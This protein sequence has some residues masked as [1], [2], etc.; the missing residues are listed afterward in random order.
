MKTTVLSVL[1]LLVSTTAVFAQLNMVDVKELGFRQNNDGWYID[2]GPDQALMTFGNL[3]KQREGLAKAWLRFAFGNEAGMEQRLFW[4][5]A[6]NPGPKVYLNE[7]W[8]YPT[9]DDKEQI[10]LDALYRGVIRGNWV[11]LEGETP[12]KGDYRSFTIDQIEPVDLKKRFYLTGRFAW[13]SEGNQAS[14]GL[15]VRTKLLGLPVH[16]SLMTGG[17]YSLSVGLLDFQ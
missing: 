17:R 14:I 12:L 3:D 16:G 13:T 7:E 8:Q 4:G 11:V 10:G 5:I 15:G 6:V 9:T 1:T 2:W